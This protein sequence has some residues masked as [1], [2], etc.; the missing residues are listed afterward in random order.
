[1]S[2]QTAAVQALNFFEIPLSASPQQMAITLSGVAYNL[3]FLYRDSQGAYPNVLPAGWIMDLS[4]V[5]N[6]LLAGAIALVTGV[7]LLEQYAYLGI[8]GAIV[9]ATDG[10][11]EAVPTYESLGTTTH[12]YYV[13]NPA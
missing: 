10:D 9:V 13:P 12:V 4:D 7:D 5:N 8:S 6:N 3:R 11:P 1:M 2:G